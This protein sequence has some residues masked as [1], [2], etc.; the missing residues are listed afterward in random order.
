MSNTSFP[1][2][3]VDE[4]NDI[5]PMDENNREFLELFKGETYQ[6]TNHLMREVSQYYQKNVVGNLSPNGLKIIK[7]QCR[8]HEQKQKEREQVQ[9]H[10]NKQKKDKKEEEDYKYQQYL[11]EKFSKKF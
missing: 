5:H 10:A 8:E 4:N 6:E 2:C 7:K 11:K 3:Y 1:Q 9:E